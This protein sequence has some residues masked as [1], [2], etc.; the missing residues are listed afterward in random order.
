MAATEPETLTV[1]WCPECGDIRRLEYGDA[2][3]VCLGEGKRHPHW[4][5]ECEPV[6]VV[7]LS[8]LKAEQ[9]RRQDEERHADT[10]ALALDRLDEHPV[11]RLG[12]G[13][14][15]R[16]YGQAALASHRQRRAS[17]HHG[18]GA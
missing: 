8:A 15:I 14:P 7:P 10:L 1:W 16:I 17:E 6:K 18:E 2:Q 3:A 9:Q 4:Y 11:L 13:D 12:S 5:R